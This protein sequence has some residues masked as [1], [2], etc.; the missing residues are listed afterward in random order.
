MDN[1]ILEGALGLG[2]AV[3]TGWE[4]R[5]GD[6]FVDARPR[7]AGPRCPV[8]GRRRGAFDALAARLWRVPDLGTSRCLVHHAPVR[9][10]C[11]EHGARRARALG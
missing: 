4:E 11:P 10:E 7:D 2:G 1:G 9:V 5:G 6:V 8:C 3:V